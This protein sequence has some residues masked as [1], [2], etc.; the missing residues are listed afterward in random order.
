MKQV[1]N[2]SPDPFAETLLS[3]E[4]I[5]I[6]KSATE[7]K[8][9]QCSMLDL[10]RG[11]EIE[12]LIGKIEVKISTSPRIEFYDGYIY[13]T[14]TVYIWLNGEVYMSDTIRTH[15][16]RAPELNAL[17]ALCIAVEKNRES[18][19]QDVFLKYQRGGK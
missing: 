2:I 9:R 17:A 4:L 13:G 14:V 15:D 7:I 11:A 8:T 3:R 18:N 6:L 16:K 12:L 5:K 19:R 10:A 1:K